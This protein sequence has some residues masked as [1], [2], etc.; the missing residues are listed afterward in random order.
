MLGTPG[1]QLP[2][3]QLLLTGFVYELD[4]LTDLIPPPGA[5]TFCGHVSVRTPLKLP[6]TWRGTA[7]DMPRGGGRP[8]DGT[9]PAAAKTECH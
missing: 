1:P 7:A 9:T 4:E 5:P 8:Q 3:L 6:V 2:L